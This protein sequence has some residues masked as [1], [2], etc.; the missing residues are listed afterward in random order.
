[1]KDADRRDAALLC[2][3]IMD[4][5]AKDGISSGFDD[6]EVGYLGGDEDGYITLEVF[7]VPETKYAEVQEFIER[8]TCNRIM[9]YKTP[10]VASIWIKGETRE[11][12]RKDA[13]NCMA[14][15][16]EYKKRSER[17]IPKEK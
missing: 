6:M 5:Y 12:F 1:M 4:K 15:Y 10:I 16:I 7:N 8:L 11:Y 9:E 2:I 17:F 14:K 13:Q 3:T